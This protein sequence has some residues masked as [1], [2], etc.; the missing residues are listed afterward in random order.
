MP[1]KYTIKLTKR[2]LEDVTYNLYGMLE[3]LSEREDQ[4]HY[5]Y[6]KRALESIYK[7]VAKQ[8]KERENEK[9]NGN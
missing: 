5:K 2:Q 7:Q 3:L 4:S 9:A 6:S 8:E 1:K